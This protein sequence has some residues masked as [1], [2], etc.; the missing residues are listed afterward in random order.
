MNKVLYYVMLCHVMLILD[1]NAQTTA[2]ASSR[3][4]TIR[5][6]TSKRRIEERHERRKRIWPTD[7]R[8]GQGSGGR[9]L[10]VMSLSH[11]Q[12]WRVFVSRLVFRVQ[13]AT[14]NYIRAEKTSIFLVVILLT[15]HKSTKFPL[16][17]YNDH[18]SK[19]I[20]QKSL[21][22]TSTQ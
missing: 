4:T 1:L 19:Y 13:S 3:R 22:H 20:R 11:D 15:S 18:L 8:I 17:S 2:R 9:K 7:E 12:Y 6:T 14:K 21:Q 5:S 16:F 10:L